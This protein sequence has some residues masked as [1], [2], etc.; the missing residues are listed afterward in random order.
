MLNI[1]IYLFNKL[2]LQL[3]QQKT[4]ILKI[5]PAKVMICVFTYMAPWC[6]YYKKNYAI[7]MHDK[8]YFLNISMAAM[9]VVVEAGP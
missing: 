7:E 2:L 6:A 8:E 4:L 5:N 9:K 3:L 1:F